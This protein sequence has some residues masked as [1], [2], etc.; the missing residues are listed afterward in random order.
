[1]KEAILPETTVSPPAADRALGPRVRL[2]LLA[3]VSVAPVAFA[4]LGTPQGHSYGFNLSWH[5]AFEAARAQGAIYPRHLP[6]LNF[7]VGGLDFFFYGPLPF[8]LSTGPAAW[9][10]PAC[11]PQTVFGLAGGILLSVSMLAFWPLARRVAPPEAAAVGCVIYAVLPYHLAIDWGLRQAAGEFAAYAFLPLV[12][13]GQMDWLAR[14]R[15]GLAFP[16]GLAGVVLCHPPTALLAA[17]V[18]GVIALGWA[19]AHPRTAGPRLAGLV[20]MGLVGGSVA[21]VYWL[22]ALVL[23]GDVSPAALYTEFLQPRTW[24]LPTEGPTPNPGMM[25]LA[26]GTALAGGAVTAAAIAFAPPEARGTLWLWAALPLVTVLFLNTRAS[27]PLWDHWIIDR[28]QFPFRLF[29]FADLAT[30][31]AAAALAGHFA[32]GHARGRRVT[33]AAGLGVLTL[34]ALAGLGLSADRFANGVALKGAPVRMIAPPE[35]QPPALAAAVARAAAAAGYDDWRVNR[36]IDENFDAF[37]EGA[38]ARERLEIRPRRWTFAPEGPGP[39]TL[40][41]PYWRHMRAETQ[42]GAI[43]ELAPE[44]QWGRTT[45]AVPAGASSIVVSLPPTRSERAGIGLSLAGLA[46]CLGIAADG[47]RRRRRSRRG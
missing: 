36:V 35:Y 15:A 32:S 18:F 22:P 6:E 47:V 11:T 27:A 31:L 9:L 46:A 16:L 37:H 39:A 1:V 45:L 26:V 5:V 42:D 13:L 30:A 17:H 14:G 34:C 41:T 24:L 33:A 12:A 20:G 38:V 4:L 2:F 29:V 28:V 44:P 25:A 19:L 7:G 23:L 40:P 21:G 3:A 43:V 10:C 8:L